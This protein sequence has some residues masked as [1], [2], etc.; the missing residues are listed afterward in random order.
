[1]PHFTDS[2]VD[3]DAA[4]AVD[5]GRE[6]LG[7]VLST[8]QRRLQNV[9]VVFVIGF[10][11]S[12]Y[13]M[14]LWVWP[15][16]KADLLAKGAVIVA[17]TPFD[18][19]LLQA[20]VGLITG[21]LL[22]IPPLLYFS[23]D[24]LRDR[25]LYPNISLSWWKTVGLGLLAALL[26]AGGIAYA[27]AVIFPVL[28][29]FLANNAIQAE[30]Q[31]T[32]SIVEWTRF[33]VVLS[34]VMGVTAE[35][36][37]IV[38]V[39][40]YTEVVPYETFRN[41][42][43]YATLGIVIFAS[44]ANGSPDPLSMSFVAIPMLLLYGVGLG[45]AKIATSIKDGGG[46][47]LS[48][49]A[50]TSPTAGQPAEIDPAVLDAAGVR[51]APPE[52]F[53]ELTEQ[54]VFAHARRAMDA[55]DPA[56][57]QAILDRYDEIHRGEEEIEA[58]EAGTD[59]A[60]DARSES[61]TD[62]RNVIARTAVGM[63]EAFTEDETTADDVGGYYYDIKFVYE[64]LT[65]KMFRLVGTFLLVAMATFAFLYRGGIGVLKR[66]FLTRVPPT[67]QPEQLNIVLLHPIEV[68]VFEMKISVILGAVA[69]L[70]LLLYY[71]WPAMQE[72]GLARGD[73][74]IF[75]SWAGVLALGLIVGSLFGYLYIAPAIISYLVYDAIRAGM[76]VAYKVPSFFWLIFL[77]SVGIGLLMEVP[78]TMIL[79]Y[80]GGIV[81]Y[82][83]MRNHW[84]EVAIGILSLGALLPEGV[85][86]MFLVAIPTLLAY[87]WGL[88]VIWVT[89]L[90]G[91]YDWARTG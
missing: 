45:C 4:R 51:A 18:V 46:I 58:M 3:E 74:S 2:L 55:D 54:Q 31:P 43:R 28:F 20:K 37:L 44:V 6:V 42:W 34:L 19:V 80:R 70:P 65:S 50:A 69:V 88:A 36:P 78:V 57:A 72:R 27:Y 76:I 84:R 39:L 35:L 61:V 23:R 53:A 21:A 32:Y 7:V 73:R 68:L 91:R 71:A 14:G 52:A 66:D 9:F 15:R 8:C 49:D 16:L 17:T 59:R 81:S 13:A 75:F 25:G 90:G 10:L 82:R 64:S 63:I 33:I 56:K 26:F 22:S 89:T 24:T 48:G 62:T 77:T 41:E 38:T 29:E 86:T 47:A 83:A 87:G 5:S 30:F 85:F 1:M 12:F 40:A 11:S 67:V 79:F 60:A